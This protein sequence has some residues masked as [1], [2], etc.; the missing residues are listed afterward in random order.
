VQEVERV[1][2]VGEAKINLKNTIDTS[3]NTCNLSAC[4]TRAAENEILRETGLID[5]RQKARTFLAAG[6]FCGV[7]VR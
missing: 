5:P 2:G 7:Q 1:S 4:R 6:F 3:D